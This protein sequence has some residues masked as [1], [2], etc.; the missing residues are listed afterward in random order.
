MGSYK[1]IKAADLTLEILEFLAD[2]RDPVTG[3]DVAEALD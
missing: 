3:Q 1:R 2:Q